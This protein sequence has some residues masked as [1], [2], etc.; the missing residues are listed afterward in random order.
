MVACQPSNAT[1][2]AAKDRAGGRLRA[3]EAPSTAGLMAAR[4]ARFNN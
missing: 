1:A 4:A 3:S 2:G